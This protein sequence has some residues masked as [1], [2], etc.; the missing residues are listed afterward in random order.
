MFHSGDPGDASGRHR[1]HARKPAP[2][3]AAE[4]G[5]NRTFRANGGRTGQLGRQ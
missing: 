4:V 2:C 1:L 3:A 5:K